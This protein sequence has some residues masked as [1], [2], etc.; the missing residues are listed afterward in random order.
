M[1]KV[2][3]TPAT[4]GLVATTSKYITSGVFSDAPAPRANV[5]ALLVVSTVQVPGTRLIRVFCRNLQKAPA[6]TV[7]PVGKTT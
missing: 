1:A 2:P 4:A 5:N 6:R 3:V 7:N